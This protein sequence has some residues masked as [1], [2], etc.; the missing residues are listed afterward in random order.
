MVPYSSP[1]RAQILKKFKILKFS[2]ELDIFK[3]ATHQTPIFCGEFWRSGLKISS[4]LEIFKRSWKFQA[5][6]NFFKIWALRVEI[7]VPWHKDELMYPTHPH[8]TSIPSPG[9]TI[10]HIIWLSFGYRLP[11]FGPKK[12][13]N[14]GQTIA[15]WYAK[16]TVGQGGNGNEREVGFGS[17]PWTFVATLGS[18]FLTQFWRNF[19]GFLTHFGRSSFPNK[20]RPILTHFWR[21]SDAFLTIADAFSENTFWTIPTILL[22]GDFFETFRGF[23]LCRCSGRSPGEKTPTFTTRL[24]QRHSLWTHGCFTTKHLHAYSLPL[25]F[26]HAAETDCQN[27]PIPPKFWGCYFTP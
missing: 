22:S 6:L 20:T 16:W 1:L 5:L 13:R 7:N 27:K 15:K 25:K 26:I 4:E 11:E 12:G 8:I 9:N 10:W 18:A 19:D 2:C 3:R 17:V 14:D 24:S 23:G 21:I